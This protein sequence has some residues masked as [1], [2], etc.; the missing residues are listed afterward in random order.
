MKNQIGLYVHVPFCVKKCSYCGFYS[1][2]VE[3]YDVSRVIS[4]IIKE[5]DSYEAVCP[6]TIYIGGGSP[7]CLPI[8]ELERL[9]EKVSALNPN[10]E[11]TV[12]LNPS[13][14]TPKLLEV[15]HEG[16][17]NRISIGAQ[18]FNEDELKILGR[19][20][21][22]EDAIRAVEL[23]REIGFEN[24]GLDMIFAV[25][26]SDLHS[27]VNSINAAILLEIKHISAY[28]L[29][30]EKGTPLLKQKENGSL[31]VVDEEADRR[32][33]ETAIDILD[34]AGYGQYEISNFAMEGYNCR[35]NIGY[36]KNTEYVGVGPSAGSL[37]RRKRKMNEADIEGYVR[38]V[39]AGK[40][41]AV[42]EIE[43]SREDLACETMVLG[44]RLT[45]GVSLQE[46]AY[47][48][49][50]RAEEV[51]KNA[52][53]VHIESGLIEMSDS[54]VRLTKDGLPVADR[55]LCDFAAF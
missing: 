25:P 50:F 45:E 53:K 7:S 27:W 21:S 35:H 40:S 24:I 37:Y 33:Y 28:S 1:E 51:F 38:A 32:M 14:V 4:T 34:C 6:D 16:R 8:G 42:E 2:P 48:T 31:D 17:V 22:P 46:F 43:V 5:I 10:A 15:L 47:K 3:G 19:N 30:Y 41:A 26:G 55:I 52:L 11:F 18:S 9:V 13:Q 12:E 23:A 54:K 44:L 29:S 20:H 36:W 49:G 39:E